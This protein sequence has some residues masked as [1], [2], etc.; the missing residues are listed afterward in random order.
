MS[1]G[2]LCL[3]PYY[4]FEGMS[5]EDLEA[6][7]QPYENRPVKNKI[8]YYNDGYI[9]KI[10][11]AAQLGQL[12]LG[13]RA[14]PAAL[15]AQAIQVNQAAVQAVKAATAPPVALPAPPVALP[16][17]AW[18]TPE[19][20]QLDY[21]SPAAQAALFNLA[22]IKQCRDELTHLL[23][24]HMHELNNACNGST[25]TVT[26]GRGARLFRFMGVP[27]QVTLCW[28]KVCLVNDKLEH[29]NRYGYENIDSVK[30]ILTFRGAFENPNIPIARETLVK[31][32]T[33]ITTN[34]AI[35]RITTFEFIIL[36][37]KIRNWV[38]GKMDTLTILFD[39]VC[40]SNRFVDEGR[41]AFYTFKLNLLWT[42][43]EGMCYCGKYSPPQLRAY[44]KYF[45][46][47]QRA[48]TGMLTLSTSRCGTLKPYD[49]LKMLQAYRFQ[50]DDNILYPTTN[51]YKYISK[52][53]LISAGLVL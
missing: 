45:M 8:R 38:Y 1:D 23:I 6:F 22:K 31:L 25:I 48:I 2:L 36:I 46:A 42:Q 16:A 29:L 28:F 5:L 53:L 32:N 13:N 51:I 33:F 18:Q 34:A 50:M 49:I 11:I 39:A 21:S 52:E 27:Y 7:C 17:N 10:N 26:D 12:T 3:N 44:L 19:I 15:T 14:T 24:V 41:P 37:S 43:F 47:I 30:S 4:L 40:A 9:S 35:M 20:S